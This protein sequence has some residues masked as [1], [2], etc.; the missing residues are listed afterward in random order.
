MNDQKIDQF[1]ENTGRSA[2]AI[3]L[4]SVFER[5]HNYIYANEGLLKEK[6]G[7]FKNAIELYKEAEEIFQ[8]LD[9]RKNLEQVRSRIKKLSEK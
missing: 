5:C 3:E 4:I 8:R 6:Q 7:E 2:T 1:S 9:I